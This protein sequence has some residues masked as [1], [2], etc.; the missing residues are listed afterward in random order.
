M[1]RLADPSQPALSLDYA[2]QRYALP[3]EL[4]IDRRPSIPDRN[5]MERLRLRKL[6]RFL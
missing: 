4:K 1:R 6:A 5:P 2:N 3:R